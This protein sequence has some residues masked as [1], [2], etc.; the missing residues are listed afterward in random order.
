MILLET[1]ITICRKGLRLA[2]CARQ[3]FTTGQMTN[4]IAL[5]TQKL[6]EVISNCND[7]DAEDVHD[8]GDDDGAHD[9]G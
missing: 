4:L 3:E 1:T 7:R 8:H 5:D 6:V 2:P 9:A